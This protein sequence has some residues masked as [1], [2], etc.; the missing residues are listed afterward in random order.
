MLKNTFH[1]LYFV[2]HILYLYLVPY[3]A[4][5]FSNNAAMSIDLAIVDSSSK[6]ISF[7]KTDS[8]IAAGHLAINLVYKFIADKTSN[9]TVTYRNFRNCD[10]KKMSEDIVGALSCSPVTNHNCPDPSSIVN[11]FSEVLQHSLH[12]HAPYVTRIMSRR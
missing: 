1:I 10:K 8:P 5:N 2:F 7:S 12:R 6:L 11:Y 9:E 3:G 4:T